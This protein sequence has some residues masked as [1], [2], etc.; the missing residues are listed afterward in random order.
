MKLLC[1]HGAG[2]N[3]DVSL[4]CLHLKMFPNEDL[5]TQVLKTQLGMLIH[6]ATNYAR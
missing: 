3:A 1:L 6:A 4:R 5:I 2:T